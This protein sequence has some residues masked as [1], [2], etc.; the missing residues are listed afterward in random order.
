M[1]FLEGRTF[2]EDR[3]AAFPERRTFREDYNESFPE[4]Q[5]FREI[6]DE[7]FPGGRSF[8]GVILQEAGPPSNPLSEMIRA[9]LG[10]LLQAASTSLAHR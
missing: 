6:S 4:G 9:S 7:S 2:R 1:D 8:R 3:D 5:T 10:L